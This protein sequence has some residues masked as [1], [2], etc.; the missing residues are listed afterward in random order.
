LEKP[1]EID[2]Q[3]HQEQKREVGKDSS[4]AEMDSKR[5][6]AAVTVTL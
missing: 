5:V 1:Q 4:Q 3:T 6:T 2:I